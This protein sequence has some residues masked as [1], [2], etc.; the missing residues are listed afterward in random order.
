MDTVPSERPKR[1]C[2]ALSAPFLLLLLAGAS[3]P[4][5]AP[6]RA[7]VPDAAA[8]ADA[9]KWVKEQFKDDYAKPDPAE[10]LAL[11][12]KLLRQAAEPGLEDKPAR[13]HVMLREARDLAAAAGDADG[14]LDAAARLSASFDVDAAAT[15]AEALEA[16]AASTA[17]VMPE[18]AAGLAHAAL[19]VA[20]RAVEEGNFS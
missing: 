20:E 17:M 6:T 13:R 5:V 4:V 19:A 12:Q 2:R 18:A 8:L 14:A 7:P 10:R 1:H 9:A 3:V 15:R 11:A 16:A